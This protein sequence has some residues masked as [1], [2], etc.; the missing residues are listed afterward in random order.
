VGK[1]TA[2]T[3]T[4]VEDHRQ[5]IG[6]ALAEWL[7][8]LTFVD[9]TVEEVTALLIDA[10]AEWAASQ[11][12]RTYR[13]AASVLPLPPPYSNQFSVLD[14][15]CA[16][17]A[18]PPVV[19]EVDHTHRRR[20]ID[21]LLAESAAGRA[22][23]W[24]RWSTGRIQPAPAEII[25]APFPVTARRGLAGEG[26]RYSRHLS[27]DRPPPVHSPDPVRVGEQGTIEGL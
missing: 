18:G 21:K 14:L 16:R 20:T 12:W 2:L 10:V 3:S 22:A 5:D 15:A 17:P 4:T 7:G 1:R 9:R 25:L 11:G 27:T 13:R 23:V 19:V 24:I 6:A 8:R 26:L